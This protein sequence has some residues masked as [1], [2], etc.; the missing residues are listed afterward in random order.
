MRRLIL[1]LVL[2]AVAC[3]LP[4]ALTPTPPALPNAFTRTPISSPRGPTPTPVEPLEPS[5]TPVPSAIATA[6]SEAPEAFF[7]VSIL[8]DVSSEP[9]PH[10]SLD[11]VL[12]DASRILV[13]HTRIAFELIEVVEGIPSSTVSEFAWQYVNGADT[14]PNGLILFSFGDDDRARTYGGYSFWVLG[15][16]GFQNSYVSPLAGDAHVYV[17]A[18]HWG[19]RYARCGYGEAEEPISDVSL[20]GECFNQSGTPCVEHNGYSFCSSAL[21]DLYAQTPTAFLAA[22]IVHEFLHPFGVNG[23]Y[24]HYGTQQCLE[25]MGWTSGGW[26]HSRED[27]ERSA[28]MCPNVFEAFASSHRP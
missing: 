5:V 22:N 11:G 17:A 20:G 23:V 27:A 13:E 21:A 6:T 10:E 9:V 24:D 16:A 12:A 28:G 3:A 14:V 4:S 8:I 1:T 19:H 15:P 18:L 25:A 26:V 7:T 2:T